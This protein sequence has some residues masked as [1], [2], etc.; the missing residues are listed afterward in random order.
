MAAR[1]LLLILSDCRPQSSAM[2]SSVRNSWLGLLHKSQVQ[3]F[4]C[5]GAGNDVHL[6]TSASMLD[7]EAEQHGDL[8]R[9]ETPDGYEFLSQKVLACLS[10]GMASFHD[11]FDFFVKTDHDVFLRLDILGPEL[12]LLLARHDA[13]PVRDAEPLL[14]W[15]GFVYHSI[16]PMRDL[17]DKNA[18]V[19]NSLPFFPPYTAGVAYVL[20]APLAAELVTIESPAFMLNEDQ[21]LGVWMEQR[22]ARGSRRVSPMHDVRFQQLSVCFPGQVAHHFKE[23]PE[24]LMSLMSDNIH[25]GAEACT[26]VAMSSCCLCCDCWASEQSW[27]RC[28]TQ[29][30]FLYMLTPLSA[31]LRAPGVQPAPATDHSSALLFAAPAL[32]AAAFEP[33]LSSKDLFDRIVSTHVSACALTLGAWNALG[34]ASLAQVANNSGVALSC[35]AAL[36]SNFDIT[37]HFCASSVTFEVPPAQEND[38]AGAATCAPAPLAA[39]ISRPY[40]LRERSLTFGN[41]G[42]CPR[43]SGAAPT[44]SYR[45]ADS[46]MLV[47]AWVNTSGACMLD[48]LG[49]NTRASMLRIEHGYRGPPR[50]GS[51]ASFCGLFVDV[52]HADGSTTSW[53]SSFARNASRHFHAEVFRVSNPSPI[54]GAVI[55]VKMPAAGNLSSLTV[56]DVSLRALSFSDGRN[57]SATRAA[58]DTLSLYAWLLDP[59]QHRSR[60]AFRSGLR[61]CSED[62]RVLATLL[63]VAAMAYTGHRLLRQGTCAIGQRASFFLSMLRSIL[64]RVQ[65]ILGKSRGD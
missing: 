14:H 60:L 49:H 33:F 26:G 22:L 7:L 57:E 20:S 24:Q 55:T 62:W 12:S 2:R 34:V 3:H 13:S 52:V 21:T 41:P 30:A 48:G 28:D 53:P 65:D 27:F 47:A 5:V 8:F 11:T 16:P 23:R 39:R 58:I 9:V 32:S 36:A 17:A 29:G 18:D 45:L 43:G 31:A 4:F 59:R 38:G 40:G 56:S 54:V 25:K 10:V 19:S 44:A 46:W 6:G 15:Q 35:P 61:L 37:R 1:L 51:Y 64:Q 42:R 63:V 50:F